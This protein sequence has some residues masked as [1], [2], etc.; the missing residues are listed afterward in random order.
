M[1]RLVTKVR[2]SRA[3]FFFHVLY[4]SVGFVKRAY[5]INFRKGQGNQLQFTFT[6]QPV[7]RGQLVFLSHPANSNPPSMSSPPYVK[8]N[9]T[10]CIEHVT[11]TIAIAPLE[12]VPVI[13]APSPP[14]TPPSALHRFLLAMGN[15]S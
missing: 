6:G 15:R 8:G 1:K 7:V 13:M 4:Q 10:C 14:L 12:I 11:N 2:E 9:F 5:G 3:T